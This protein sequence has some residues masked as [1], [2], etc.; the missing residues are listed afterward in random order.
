MNA[1]DRAEVIAG[2]IRTAAEDKIDSLWRDYVHAWLECQGHPEDRSRNSAQIR[3]LAETIVGD[4][5]HPRIT[6]D[7]TDLII[8]WV[9]ASRDNSCPAPSKQQADRAADPV[10]M[11][12]GQFVYETQDVNINGAG[13]TFTFRRTYKNQLRYRGPLGFNWSHNHNLFVRVGAHTI[14]RSTGDLREE[15]YTRHPRFGE[16]GFSYWVPPDGQDGVLLEHGS[17]LVWRAPHGVRHFFVPDA[18]PF[19]HRLDRIEDRRGN[20]LRY[21]YAEN[22][23]RQ[24]EINHPLRVVVFD[25]D[26][27]DRITSVRDYTGRTW[28]YCYDSFGDLVSVVTPAT[29]EYPEGL[30]VCYEYSSSQ[31][32]GELQHNLTRIVDA[33]GKLYLENE[34]GSERG[35]PRFNRVVRQRQGGGEFTFDYEDVVQEFD[36]EYSDDE[37]PAHQTTRV[38][39]NGHSVC[40]IYNKFGNLLSETQRILEDGRLRTLVWRYRFNRDGALIASLSAEGVMTQHLYGREHFARRHGTTPMG[41]V[42]FDQLTMEERQAFGHLKATVKRGRRFG[43]AELNLSR[44]VWGDIFPD[45]VAAFDSTDSVS[46]FTYEPTYGQLLT[47]SDPR[48]TRTPDPAVQS[49]ATGEH[50]LYEATLT[51]YSY[52][53]PATNPASDPT[54]LLAEIRQPAP[55]LPDGTTAAPPVDR[56][57]EYDD[58]GRLLRAVNAA[59]TETVHTYFGPLTGVREGHRECTTVD[60]GGLA[61][62]TR[63]EV[64]DLGRTVAVHAPRSVNAPGEFVTR[65]RYNELDQVVATVSPEPFAFE[66]RLFYDRSG[67]LAREER[68]AK[69]EAGQDRPGGP[70]VR[71][72]TY[73]EELNLIEETLGGAARAAHLVKRHRYDCGGLQVLTTFPEGNKMRFRYDARQLQI[74]EIKGADSEDAAATRSEY[75]GDGRLCALIDARGHRT[76]FLCDPFGRV[77]ETEDRDGNVIL[78]DYDKLDQVIYKRVFEKRADGYYLLARNAVRFDELGRETHNIVSRFDEPRGPVSRAQLAGAFFHT[79]IAGEQLMVGLTFFD[80]R[81]RAVKTVDPLQRETHYECDVLDRATTTIDPLGNRVMTRYDEHNNVVRRENVDLVRDP[82]DPTLV[83]GQRVFATSYT[84]DTLDRVTSATESLGNVT[85][86]AYDSRGRVVKTVDPLGNVSTTAYDI[87]GRRVAQTSPLTA[88]GLGGGAVQAEAR[89]TFE[90]DRNGNLVG[91]TDRRGRQTTFV[92]DALDRRRAAVLPDGSRFELDYDADGHVIRTRDNNGLQ[93]HY[94]IDPLGRTTGLR[95]DTSGVTGVEIGGSRTERYAFDALNRTR[96]EENDFVSL[97]TRFDSIGVPISERVVFK[98]PAA[99]LTTPLEIGRTPDIAGALV[100]LT[101]PSGRTLQLERDALSRLT[102]VLNLAN[103]AGYPGSAATPDVYTIARFDFAG[104]QRS[105]RRNGNGT[106]TGYAHDGAARLIDIDHRAAPGPALKLQYLFDGA[107]NL[108]SRHEIG[109]SGDSAEAFAYDSLQRLVNGRSEAR[110]PFDPVP[111]GPATAAPP[112][113]IPRRQDDLDQAIGPLA[114]PPAPHTFDYDLSGNRRAD[115]ETGARSYA[116]NELDQYVEVTEAVTSQ[117]IDLVYNRNGN[118]TSD[119]ARS[120]V[121]DSRNRL[122]KVLQGGAP[123]AEFFHDTRGRRIMEAAGGSATQLVWNGLKVIEEYRDSALVAQYVHGEGADHLVQIAARDPA[124]PAAGA[125]HWYHTDLV[126][127]VR[128]LT[129]SAGN[130]AAHYGY[131]PFGTL[132]GA[133]ADEPYN[134]YRFSGKRLDAALGTYDFHLRQYDPALGRFLQRDPTAPPGANPYTYAANAPLALIDPSGAEARAEMDRKAALERYF[135]PFW[136]KLAESKE[137]QIYRMTASVP[138][139]SKPGNRKQVERVFRA[140]ASV[141][142]EIQDSTIAGRD[143]DLNELWDKEGAL[144]FKYRGWTHMCGRCQANPSFADVGPWGGELIAGIDPGQVYTIVTSSEEPNP[145]LAKRIFRGV[146]EGIILFGPD[147]ALGMEL[148]LMRRGALRASGGGFRGSIRPTF[149]DEYFRVRPG[150]SVAF[151]SYGSYGVLEH[152]FREEAMQLGYKT[153]GTLAAES[154][155]L[156]IP[157]PVPRHIRNQGAEAIVNWE[158]EQFLKPADRIG[159]WLT[160][161]EHS[162]PGSITALEL[163]RIMDDP[164]LFKKTQFYVNPAVVE[165]VP[166]WTPTPGVVT[167]PGVPPKP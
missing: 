166:N 74:A 26:A 28:S 40:Q 59:G 133:A 78:R 1:C 111:L 36:A 121:Y 69:D 30:T 55:T 90:Y 64:D 38:E 104:H 94:T 85:T 152:Q 112:D 97:E 7:E 83:I 115:A 46:K 54:R 135:K 84:Y 138:E 156:G 165:T 75:D 92:Y 161:S 98:G 73:D 65:T 150:D 86:F 162:W 126:G 31:Y 164:V 48:F 51:R 68:D 114:L 19:V 96:H 61:I 147:I 145:S 5:K 43:L 146:V 148:S 116:V 87:Y 105:G 72:F 136:D 22:R 42:P 23:L 33:S 129:D 44:G 125:E 32:S 100:A 52:K 132:R 144:D 142:Q 159:F 82:D 131:N 108:R 134:P 124:Q 95:V 122:V 167:V 16:A 50:P 25:Y 151:G 14:F 155:R 140:Y 153:V 35:L 37:R 3:R 149:G 47:V 119:G 81:N 157:M 158:V 17:S 62:T 20:Y 12:N 9:V 130:I 77:I 123:V 63:F 89:H 128:V 18:L 39:R 139:D 102:A 79:P 160:A 11:F 8:G 13:V 109:S 58:R 137:K 80:A 163:Q 127:S 56:F 101:Y 4:F 45:I 24:I 103:G 29:A 76:T 53:G 141:L 88:T 34:Y 71:T 117:V 41:D 21:T 66:T 91:V 60:P 27:Q 70:E 118:L 15:P 6:V 107:N 99:P 120:Y 2:E 10:T 106:A 67:K 49:A 143:L 93:H 113:P 154:K 110:A 57:E